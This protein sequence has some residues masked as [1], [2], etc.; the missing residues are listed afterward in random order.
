MADL[1]AVLQIG[2]LHVGLSD[3]R[4]ER[5]REGGEGREGGKRQREGRRQREGQETVR[6]RGREGSGKE[7]IP[8]IRTKL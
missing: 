1:T 5:G 8:L 7:D 2:H 6:R 3:R 4:G